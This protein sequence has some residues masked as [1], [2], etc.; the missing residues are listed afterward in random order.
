M[1]KAQEGAAVGFRRS[2][3]AVL[4][5][6]ELGFSPWG[7][8]VL[9]ALEYGNASRKEAREL[10][11]SLFQVIVLSTP[12]THRLAGGPKTLRWGAGLVPFATCGV[13]F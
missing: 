1:G 6:R 8:P 10:I 3:V 4:T 13:H 7:L 11:M 9:S 5:T 12:S 2:R